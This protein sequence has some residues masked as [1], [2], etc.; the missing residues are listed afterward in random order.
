MARLRMII[1]PFRM[2][3]LPR[4]GA[5]SDLMELTSSLSILTGRLIIIKR[6]DDLGHF[7]AVIKAATIKMPEIT[8]LFLDEAA[9]LL[10]KQ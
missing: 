5:F 7:T 2:P 6:P 9:R 10:R 1:D 3:P 8:E 4:P